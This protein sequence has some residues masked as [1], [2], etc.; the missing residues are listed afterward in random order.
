VKELVRTICHNFHLPYFTL[1][2][3]FS[4]CA[5]HGYIVGN[6]AT[7]PHCGDSTE[8]YSR[9]VGYLRPIKQW[10]DGKQAEFVDRKTYTIPKQG[11]QP[12]A[13]EQI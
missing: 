10:N 6:H 5:N 3:S 1:S 4:V 2:P 9:V 8:V 12:V 7:C 13:Y 11:T